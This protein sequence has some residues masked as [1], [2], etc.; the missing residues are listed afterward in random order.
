MGFFYSYIFVDFFF[1]SFQFISFFSAS[2]KT[3]H[4]TYSRSN[5]IKRKKPITSKASLKL[6]A[7]K[8][9]DCALGKKSGEREKKTK[10]KKYTKT[11]NILSMT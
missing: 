10:R 7:A 4:K 11:Y 8:M 2:F 5:E 9:K 1:I 6:Y 3:K